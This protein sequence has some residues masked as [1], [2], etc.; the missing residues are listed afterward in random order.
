MKLLKVLLLISFIAW[1]LSGSMS[2]NV[3][4]SCFMD[5]A[6]QLPV[7]ICEHAK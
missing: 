6:P 3:V 2:A 1:L 5:A 4:S 7:G